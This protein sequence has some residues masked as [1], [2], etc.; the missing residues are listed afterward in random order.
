MQR[1]G[2][3]EEQDPA[4]PGN[5]TSAPTTGYGVKAA[6]IN[7]QFIVNAPKRDEREEK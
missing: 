1:V 5:F 2:F 7:S 4:P 6:L 3:A